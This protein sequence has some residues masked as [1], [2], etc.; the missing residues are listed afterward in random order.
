M[1][2]F[3]YVFTLNNYTEAQERALR[4]CVGNTGIKYI[5]FGRETA[6][7]TGTPHLQGYLQVNHDNTK[8]I[9]TKLNIVAVKARGSYRENYT[10]CTKGGDF[11]EAGEA[12]ELKGVSQGKRSDLDSVHEAIK[13]GESYQE[14][15]ETHFKEMAKYSRFIR[16]QIMDRDNGAELTLSLRDY[17]NVV[18]K[19]WQASVL[20]LIETEPDRRKI[21]WIWESTGHVGKSWVAKYIAAKYGAILLQPAKGADLAHIISKSKSKIV[22]FDMARTLL[23]SEGREHQL[24]SVYSLAECLKNGVVQTTKYDSGTMIRGTSTV[25]FFANFPPDLSKWSADRYDVIHI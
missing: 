16:E 15:C 22:I 20:D 13:R 6:P 5:L 4:G 17:D 12:E 14:I 18:W 19:P 11:F 9:N 1:R 7:T 2:L 23:P 10:Y 24:D 3:G 8:R 25:I 21:H